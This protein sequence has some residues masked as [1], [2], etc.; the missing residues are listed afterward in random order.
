MAVDET[1]FPPARPFPPP[2]RAPTVRVLAQSRD[3]LLDLIG[4]GRPTQFV[5]AVEGDPGLLLEVLRRAN[6]EPELA[7]TIGSAR[8][9]VSRS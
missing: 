4:G 5:D 9:A 1:R 3:R 7:G 8:R 2:T 6:A